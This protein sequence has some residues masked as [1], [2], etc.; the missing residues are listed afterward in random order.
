MTV[1]NPGL[2]T[3]HHQVGLLR[4]LFPVAN[5]GVL[6]QVGVKLRL[7]VGG[8]PRTGGSSHGEVTGFTDQLRDAGG[9]LSSTGVHL[10]PQR[11]ATHE[12]AAPIG[13]RDPIWEKDDRSK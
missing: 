5:G 4:H 10:F 2:M 3:G 6:H 8:K 13:D 1:I 11:V 12:E 9:A 7:L